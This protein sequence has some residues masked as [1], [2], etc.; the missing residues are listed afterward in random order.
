MKKPNKRSDISLINEEVSPLS[1][2]EDDQQFCTLMTKY[3]KKALVRRMHLDKEEGAE[4]VEMIQGPRKTSLCECKRGMLLDNWKEYVR[5]IL[6]NQTQHFDGFK[7][8]SEICK[9]L[10]NSN[11]KLESLNKKLT[12]FVA[13]E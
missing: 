9:D 12:N 1:C 6:E 4:I 7:Y 5:Y 3:G 11:D 13:K 2:L 8:L 10:K